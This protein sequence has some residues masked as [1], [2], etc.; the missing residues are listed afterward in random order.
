MFALI[1]FLPVFVLVCSKGDHQGGGGE[2]GGGPMAKDWFTAIGSKARLLIA[3]ALAPA[4]GF[5]ITSLI[6]TYLILLN[7]PV[8]AWFIFYVL[9]W[10]I[11][12]AVFFLYFVLRNSRKSAG[13]LTLDKDMIW[14]LSGTSLTAIVVALPM[15]LGGLQFTTLRGNGVDD[16]NYI[17]MARYLDQEPYSWKNIASTNDLIEKDISYPLAA[18]LLSTRWTTSAVLAYTAHVSN[19]PIYLF[20]YPYTLLFFIMSFGPG[21]LIGRR[22]NLSRLMSFLVALMV[23]T[24]FWAQFVLDIRAFSEINSIPLILSIGYLVLQFVDVEKNQL[25]RGSVLLSIFGASLIFS[26]AE[27]VPLCILSILIFSV[28]LFINKKLS[29]KLLRLVGIILVLTLLLVFPLYSLLSSF[30]IGQL[31]FATQGINFGFFPWLYSYPVIGFWGLVPFTYAWKIASIPAIKFILNLTLNFLGGVLYFIALAMIL[32]VIFRKISGSSTLLVVSFVLGTLTEFLYFYAKGQVWAAGK[33]LAY[34]YPYFLFLAAGFAS[35]KKI[36]F[37]PSS[38]HKG[39]IFCISIWLV[40]QIS[41]GAARNVVAVTGKSYVQYTSNHQDYRKY[42]YDLSSIKAY[43]MNKPRSIVW[44][45]LPDIYTEEYINF[46]F[47]GDPRLRD[48]LTA[49]DHYDPDLGHQKLDGAPEY[50]LTDRKALRSNMEF[51]QY[52]VAQNS[53]FFLLK[54]NHVNFLFLVFSTSYGVENWNGKLGFWVGK[55][56]ALITVVSSADAQA[57]FTAYFIPGPSLPEKPTRDLRITSNNGS[58]SNVYTVANEKKEFTFHMNRGENSISIEAI[59]Q[60]TLAQ[61]PNGDTRI[62]VVGLLD[63]TINFVGIKP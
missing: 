44:T 10:V 17:A 37:L 29:W 36:A 6:S 9:F 48:A 11:I 27:I 32:R 45:I 13:S 31:S 2:A 34:G 52:V 21:Y 26:Y 54:V 8:Q 7:F 50:V 5:A 58:S 42:N 59:D 23:C 24:G 51:M 12:N 61:L 3:I 55:D 28:F 25:I 62:L 30:L 33:A 4:A 22:L 60:P 57:E 20:E 38:L 47:T 16:F 19:M 41:L 39:L 14:L 15:L 43:L 40:L 35:E 49:A 53:S 1:G 18:R 46:A 56:P 63:P